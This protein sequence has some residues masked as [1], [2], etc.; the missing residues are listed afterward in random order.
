MKLQDIYESTSIINDVK[1]GQFA[2]IR[3]TKNSNDI[4]SEKRNFKN[5]SKFNFSSDGC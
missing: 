3:L 5:S 1:R 2:V 4:H